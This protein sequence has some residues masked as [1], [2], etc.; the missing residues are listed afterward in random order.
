MSDD[1]ISRSALLN[2]FRDF[3]DMDCPS[4]HTVTADYMIELAEDAP[5][6]DAEPVRHGR[7]KERIVAIPWCEDDV[8]VYVACSVCDCTMPGATNYCPDC[9][10]KMMDGDAND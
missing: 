2:T 9:G 8:D 6:V 5:S 4:G 1:L 10:A 7:W 3:K